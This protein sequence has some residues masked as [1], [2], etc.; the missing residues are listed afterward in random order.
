M[1]K[2]FLDLIG[3]TRIV[4]KLKNLPKKIDRR[5]ARKLKTIGFIAS[6]RAKE[7]APYKSGT[8]QN[9]IT[10]KVGKD[11]VDIYIPPSSKAGKYAQIREQ[12]I[13]NYG[14][15]TKSKGSK[16]GRMYMHRAIRDEK[17]EIVNETKTVF[18]ML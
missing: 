15:G 14:A 16:A 18:Q 1:I 8:L 13:Y 3:Y 6:K 10:F 11:F 7:Y 12:E 4:N 17:D 5:L 9:A 2:F